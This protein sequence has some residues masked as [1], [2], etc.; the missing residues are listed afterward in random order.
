MPVRRPSVSFQQIRNLCERWSWAD[1]TTGVRVTGFNVP[2]EARKT[3]RQ[4]PFYVRYVT[5]KGR[6]EHGEVISLKVNT[7]SHQRLVKFTASGECRWL[8][9]YLIIEIDGYRVVTH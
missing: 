6:Y 2:E 5:G 9:D 3:A 7:R 4:V 1:P 8:R